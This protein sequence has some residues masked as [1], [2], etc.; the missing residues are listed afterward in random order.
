MDDEVIVDGLAEV[1]VRPFLDVEHPRLLLVAV[2]ARKLLRYAAGCGVDPIS[3][4]WPL[5]LGS[6]W[7]VGVVPAALIRDD[8]VEVELQVLPVLLLGAGDD[9]ADVLRFS[10][11]DAALGGLDVSLLGLFLLLGRLDRRLDFDQRCLKGLYREAGLGDTFL[12]R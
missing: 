8:G 9:L 6:G 10:L 2:S 12:H 5:V 1:R 3:Q 11:A 7:L 4:L